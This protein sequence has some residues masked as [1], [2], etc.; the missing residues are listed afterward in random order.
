MSGAEPARPARREGV[1]DPE[2]P[3]GPSTQDEL[4]AY[5]GRDPG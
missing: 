5:T 3:V 2:L 1:F 4:L